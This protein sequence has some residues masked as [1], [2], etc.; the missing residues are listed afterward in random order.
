MIKIFKHFK[1]YNW[2]VALLIVGLI[3]FQVALEMELIE[4]TGN[5]MEVITKGTATKKILWDLAIKMIVISVI[6]FVVISCVSLLASFTASTVAMRIRKKL[7]TKVN[8]FSMEEINKF[9]TASLITRSTNDI[10]QIQQTIQMSLRMAITAPTM[11]IFSL[12]K[13]VNVNMQLSWITAVSLILMFALVFTMVF[14]VIPKFTQIQKKTDKINL[15][16]RENLTGL[17][18]VRAYNAEQVQQD[19]FDN[20]NKDLTKT[21]LYVNRVLSMLSPGLNFVM[22]GMYIAIYWVGAYL[23]GKNMVGYNDLTVFTQYSMHI[24]M[25]F[26]FISMLFIMIPRGIASAKRVD[27]VLTTPVRVASGT[28]NV[29]PNNGEVVFDKVSFRYPDADGYVLHDISFSAHKGQTVAFIGSTGSGKSTLINLIPRFYDATEGTITI[30]GINIKDYTL[31]HLHEKI[32]YVPQK[33]T[34]FRGSIRENLTYG[35]H[36]ATIEQIQNALATAQAKDFVDKLEGGIEYNIAQGG[37][38]VSGGQR[39]RLSIARAV[40]R[41]PEIYIFDDSFSALDYK[42]DKALREALK[43]HSANATTFIVAQRIGTI[44]DADQII[45]LDGGKIVGQ[46]THKQL[47]KNCKIYKEIALSQ[48]SKEE[49]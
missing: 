4:Q 43:K 12:T 33:A 34:L 1:W 38:N 24:L 18:V 3:V 15:I 2:I 8:D 21:N 45:V 6:I 9:S 25:S 36:D 47:L 26:M 30:D 19:K 11:A 44:M 27:E 49:L 29:S 35:N 28:V 41:E 37:K 23:I 31:H 48:L 14:I 7:F 22:N 32:G 17:R 16:T 20:A 39:Q 42:T 46:G 13:V 40:V 5:I 10:T